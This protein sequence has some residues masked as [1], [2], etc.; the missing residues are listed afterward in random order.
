MI[1]EGPFRPI[2][3]I[4]FPG[5][6]D[7]DDWIDGEDIC[8]QDPCGSPDDPYLINDNGLVDLGTGVAACV[9]EADPAFGGHYEAHTLQ[10]YIPVAPVPAAWPACLIGCESGAKISAGW[11]DKPDGWDAGS[12]AA[13]N[14]PPIPYCTTV[15][16]INANQ[17]GNDYVMNFTFLIQCIDNIFENCC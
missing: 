5:D 9:C 8:G 10:F 13:I 17:V 15:L 2:S 16:R 3:A 1:D 11:P 6:S 4:S 12:P 7:P 14:T